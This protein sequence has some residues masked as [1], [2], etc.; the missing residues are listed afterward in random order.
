MART[1]AFS[2]RRHAFVVWHGV[3]DAPLGRAVAW[4]CRDSRHGVASLAPP[5]LYGGQGLR[6]GAGAASL[7]VYRFN[8]CAGNQSLEGMAGF[9]RAGVSAD[10]LLGGN[11]LCLGLHQSRPAGVSFHRRKG[12]A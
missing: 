6:P 11:L 12:S 4:T 1:A 9:W 3:A 2:C 5:L 7:A 8:R 10:V